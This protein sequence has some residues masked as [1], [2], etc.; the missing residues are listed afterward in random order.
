MK[1]NTRRRATASWLTPAQYQLVVR[2][3]RDLQANSPAWHAATFNCNAFV[4]VIAHFVGLTSPPTWLFP[5]DFVN[6]MQRM[7]QGRQFALLPGAGDAYARSVRTKRK[8]SSAPD[9]LKAFAV[10]PGTA[11]GVM[12]ERRFAERTC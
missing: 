12:R 8:T 2:R 1:S 5:D 3:I 11:P 6:S 4:G 9:K 7:N 10:M